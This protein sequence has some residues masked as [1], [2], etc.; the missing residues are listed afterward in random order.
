MKSGPSKICGRQPLENL[1]G[2]GLL[3][4]TILAVDFSSTFINIGI[5]DET[6]QQP[7][8]QDS[9]RHILKSSANMCES[10]G[11]QFFKTTTGIQSGPDAFDES[12]FVITFFNHLG[13]YRNMQ[14]QISSRR[15]NT[16]RDTRVI[17]IRVL[18]KVFSKLFCLIRSRR[19]HGIEE[20]E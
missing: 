4:Q 20:P 11:A 13:N 10:S 6:F 18:R 14:F 8:K 17:K 12:R 9:F 3:K 15:G 19:Q 2:C 7:G 1:K 16:Q 5:N